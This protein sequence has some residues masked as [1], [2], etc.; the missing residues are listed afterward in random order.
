MSGS[1]TAAAADSSDVTAVLQVA[2]TPEGS[3]TLSGVLSAPAATTVFTPTRVPTIGVAADSSLVTTFLGTFV[4]APFG[5][6]A[7]GSVDA[8]ENFLTSFDGTNFPPSR[9]GLCFLLRPP[10]LSV[11]PTVVA[12]GDLHFKT[13]ARIAR[14]PVFCPDFLLGAP[15]GWFAGWAR[16]ALRRPLGR[17]RR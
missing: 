4:R 1:A 7:E 6:T 9:W 11:C 15:A 14:G 16:L 8:S 2:I 13:A 10:F 3:V 17:R 12:G 5:I